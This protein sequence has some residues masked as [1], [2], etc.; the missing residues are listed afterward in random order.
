[1]NAVFLVPD[2]RYKKT[3]IT[4]NEYNRV[5]VQSFTVFYTAST[6][7][8]DME[9]NSKPTL[10][11]RHQTF[12]SGIAVASCMTYK[13]PHFKTIKPFSKTRLIGSDLKYPKYIINTCKFLCLRR[14]I[15][16]IIRGL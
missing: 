8:I 9:P 6:T 1:M 3:A 2:S 5:N 13:M 11:L 16:S 12:F 10:S 7:S 15:H 14:G 4:I